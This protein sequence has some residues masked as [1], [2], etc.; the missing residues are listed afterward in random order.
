[1]YQGH[2]L[3]VARG[4]GVHDDM[5][6]ARSHKAIWPRMMKDAACVAAGPKGDHYCELKNLDDNSLRE[7]LLAGWNAHMRK[8]TIPAGALLL[9]GTQERCAT[10]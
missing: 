6:L 10:R 2:P 4:R 5:R 7:E 3:C 1:M 8:L 9:V